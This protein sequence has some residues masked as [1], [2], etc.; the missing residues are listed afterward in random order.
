MST[1]VPPFLRGLVDDAA[2][3]PP[4]ELPLEEAI[5][6]HARHRTHSWLTDVV[7]PFVLP[8]AILS[9]AD[10][11]A[12]GIDATIDIALVADGDVA[13]A[14]GRAAEH[15]S[16]ALSA[17]EI[18]VR[19]VDVATVLQGIT[20]SRTAL[21]FNM[22]SSA[23]PFAEVSVFYE[24]G[25]DALSRSPGV[26][27]EAV[28]AAGAA[29][30]IRTGGLEAEAFPSLLQLAEAIAASHATGVSFKC[31]AGLHSALR[32]RDPRTGFAH[33]GFLNILWAASVAAG[34]G[35]PADI[36]HV[37]G[38]EDGDTV[39]SAIDGLSPS[40]TAEA[41]RLFVSYGS[42]SIQEPLDDLRALG[43]IGAEVAA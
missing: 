39:A 3:Y 13:A 36:A 2:I 23:A 21:D 35:G 42:C 34:G 1:Q 16:L 28:A 25:W 32:H 8:T 4:G 26:L 30:K 33:H 29:L 5:R 31:T 41:R 7:G 17:I 10:E 40:E 14:L 24:P 22:G 37:L 20:E 9:E 18:P 11:F 38:T 43:L 27:L 15:P 6:A 19:A 12:R